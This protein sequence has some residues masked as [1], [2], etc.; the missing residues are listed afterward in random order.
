MQR[1]VGRRG[2][3]LLILAFVDFGV[4]WSYILPTDETLR[5]QS[6]LFRAQIMPL[7]AWGV[8]WVAVGIA[9]F[10]GA[11]RRYDDGVGFI[12]AVGL[13][14]GW[15]TLEFIGWRAREIDSGYRPALIWIG[16]ALLV[17][18]VS[19]LREPRSVRP[20]PPEGERGDDVAAG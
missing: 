3:V 12:P 14:L 20:C 15:A 4:G 16:F 6:N 5:M 19:G 9:C 18:A 2:A 10:V 8:V 17:F 7:W 1:R 11:F 13:K